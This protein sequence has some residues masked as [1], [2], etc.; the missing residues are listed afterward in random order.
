[1]CLALYLS[2]SNS[3]LLSWDFLFKNWIFSSSQH[4]K[5]I[6][7]TYARISILLYDESPITLFPLCFDAHTI[8]HV[9][10]SLSITTGAVYSI[11]MS[12][13]RRQLLRIYPPKALVSLFIPL[14]PTRP[15]PLLQLCIPLCR[16][17]AY[18]DIHINLM[19]S[20]SYKKN[21]WVWWQHFHRCWRCCSCLFPRSTTSSPMP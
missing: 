14:V 9:G 6:A 18:L 2:P 15:L 17:L 13:K 21:F 16:C 4:I 7:T 10:F 12:L 1:M 20:G 19:S 5:T 3:K 11:S 8:V